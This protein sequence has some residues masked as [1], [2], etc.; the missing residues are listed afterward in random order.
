MITP[1]PPAIAATSGSSRDE[2]A[3]VTPVWYAGLSS[4]SLTPPPAPVHAVSAV[5]D[6]TVVPPTPTT[7]GLD[8]GQ[9]ADRILLPVLSRQPSEPVSPEAKNHCC[10]SARACANSAFKIG[11][12][13]AEPRS[14]VP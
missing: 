6:E 14:Q 3:G 13:L 11:I 4:D 7:F 10:P 8:A 9:P 12:S 5:A 1:E 2:S